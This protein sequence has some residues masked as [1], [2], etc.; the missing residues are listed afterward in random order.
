MGHMF[1]HCHTQCPIHAFVG[2]SISLC[3]GYRHLEA[4]WL[5]LKLQT[6]RTFL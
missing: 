4:G 6:C 3:Q 1:Q 5:C 2:C